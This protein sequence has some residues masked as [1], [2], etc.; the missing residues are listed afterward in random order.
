[1]TKPPLPGKAVESSAVMRASVMLQIK[2]AA[3]QSW[4]FRRFES[5]SLS[6]SLISSVNDEVEDDRH[7][8]TGSKPTHHSQTDMVSAD[9]LYPSQ[10]PAKKQRLEGTPQHQSSSEDPRSKIEYYT[11]DEDVEDDSDGMH[12]MTDKEHE[13]YERQIKESDGFDVMHFPCSFGFGKIVPLFSF[14]L[15]EVVED[16]K[17]YSQLALKQYNKIENRKLEFVKV[18]KA[19][20]QGVAGFLYF[21]T[22]DVKDLDDI[23]G[24]TMEFQAEVWDGIS[25]TTT[26][27]CRPKPSR[28]RPKCGHGSITHW[29]M[30]VQN[31]KL[32]FVKVVKANRQGVASFLY[33]ITFDVKDPDDIDGCTMEFQAEVWD[34][35]SKTTIELCRPKP[36][37]GKQPTLFD[38]IDQYALK[39][40]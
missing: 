33:F 1:M 37:R 4:R 5:L 36:S 6:H 25:K 16:L 29:K 39:C 17:S 32:E 19:N 3:L 15:D 18:V 7:S 8:R 9:V 23:V 38:G 31:R 12:E 30:C 20:R 28:E 11:Y 24:C 34:G 27:L 26:E 35:I 21:I 2:G 10:S 40:L 13:E 14:A 22:F